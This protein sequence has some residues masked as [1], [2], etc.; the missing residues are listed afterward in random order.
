MV[1]L[2]NP[3]DGANL[4]QRLEEVDMYI[5]IGTALVIIVLLLILL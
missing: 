1:E 5:G 4:L 2:Q 3:A